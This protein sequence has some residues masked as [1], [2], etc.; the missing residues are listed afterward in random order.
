MAEKARPLLRLKD[1]RVT[2]SGQAIL[3]GVTGGIPSG[4]ITAVMGTNGAGKSTLL[5]GIRG[6]SNA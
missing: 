2:L 5:N 4:R 3:K 1:I 6:R